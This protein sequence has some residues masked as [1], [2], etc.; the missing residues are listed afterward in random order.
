MEREIK[1]L[2]ILYIILYYI[3]I[4]INHI[5]NMIFYVALKV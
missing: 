2:G 1:A 5:N 3:I 4:L